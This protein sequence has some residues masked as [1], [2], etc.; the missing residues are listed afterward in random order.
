MPPDP[1]RVQAVFLAA[2][3]C[4]E[5]SARAAVLDAECSGDAELRRRVE[6]LLCAHDEFDR[7]LDVA[8]A[9]F[10]LG[11]TPLT[12]TEH[13]GREG[14]ADDTSVVTPKAPDLTSGSESNLTVAVSA[15][16]APPD[17]THRAVPAIEGY[18]VL[19]ELGRGGMGVVYRARQ[20]LLN[21]SCVL[22]MILAGVHAD[23]ESVVC[24]LAEAEAVARLQHPNIVQIHHVGEADGL[25]FFELE[26]VDGGSLDRRLDG[27][28]WPARPAAELIAA[29][30]RGVAEAH[31]QGIIHRDLKPGNVLLA[32]DGTPKIT[33]FGLAK[34]LDKDSG[35]TRTDS[36]MGSP[37]YMAPEQAAGTAKL[38]GPL[39]DVYALGAILYELL[40]GGAPFR[41]T[42]ALE[43][44]EQ[45][46]HAEP[47]P[48][49]RLVPGLPR[50]VETIALKCLQ[51]EPG[52]R[53]ESAAALAE[54]LE[55]FRGGE[56]IVARP[57]PFWERGIKWARRRP[58]IAS[59][60]AAVI[61]LLAALLGLGVLSYQ[62]ITS[63]LRIAQERREAAEAS[64]REA[65]RQT[66]VADANFARARKAVDD[67]FTTVSESQLLK[68]PG[69][70]PLRGELLESALRFYQDFL[71]ERGD[72]P[73]LRAELA[74]TQSRIGRIQAE[75]GVAA[76]ARR[77]LKSAIATYRAEIARN[78]QD[79]A[80]PAA[81]ADIWLALGDLNYNYGGQLPDPKREM[82]AA[83]QNNAELREG[84]ARS[85]PDDPDCQGDLAEAFER[86]A[87]AQ[88]QAGR[89][90]L[91]V[92]LRGAELR[93]A[94]FL[95]SPDEPRHNFGLGE[96]MANLA[97]ALT[98]SGRHE[99]ALAMYLRGQEYNRF[100]Y[101]RLPHMIDYGCDLGTSYM[102]AVRAYRKLGRSDEAVAEARKAVEHCR[103]LVR[104]HPAVP[105]VKRHFVWALEALVQSQHDAGRA[106]EA[107][108]TGRELGQWLD[109]VED[110]PNSLFDGACWHARLSLWADETKRS[111][112]DPGQDEAHREADRAVEQLQR[113]IESGFADLDAIRKNEALDP[114]RGRADFQKLVADLEER[115]T[116]RP[117]GAPVVARSEDKPAPVSVSRAERVF[118]ARADWVAVLHAVGVIEEGRNRH[119]EARAALDEA[120][121]FCEQLLGERP[122]EAPLRAPLAD[123]HRA[124]GSLDLDAGRLGE[125]AGAF[126]RA[127]EAA[128]HDPAAY[129]MVAAVHAR[130]GRWDLAAET[131]AMLLERNPEDH[132]HWCLAAALRARAG[133]PD[134]YRR[135][136]RQMLD[137][138]RETNDPAIAERAAKYCLLLP[139][140]GPERQD[141]NQLAE[142]AVAGTTGRLRQW[143]RAAKGLADYRAG[144]FADALVA[145]DNAEAATGGR[146]DW[147]FE[148]PAGCVRA[149][150]LLCLGRRDEA[151]A[152]LEKVSGL[153]RA[154]APQ[155]IAPDPGW[156]WPDLLI[157]DILHGEAEALIVFDAAFPADPF[158][159]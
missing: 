39:A 128:P 44:I 64:R 45:V 156:F 123:T 83:C 31:R 71:Q 21:R 93:L 43:I 52:K 152:A 66:K 4:H 112:A 154:N 85:R 115:L 127:L 151:R 86:L 79:L 116:S 16:D 147:N 27:T 122:I 40:T 95:K 42:S 6:T 23:A 3:E 15:G 74:A 110:Q 33:D 11:M 82:L 14:I 119:H 144:R 54:D 103:R 107:A 38:V 67:S 55:R 7:S 41:G 104:D 106:A 60:A 2:L 30:A 129:R 78:P 131:L 65:I 28:P 36:I 97:V 96:S 146:G 150:A 58:A 89:D 135:L 124:L 145:I 51:K 105:I 62:R 13:Q 72:D 141:A 92:R 76:E 101:D 5:P 10:R 108:R 136:C 20:I 133:D 142:R 29:L 32:A 84:L 87:F 53:Y 94:R 121:V 100:A 126:T 153:Y 88:D 34:A 137:R 57:V 8:L 19:G 77:T 98:N 91:P 111:V 113:A 114:L 24:F 70:Q 80:L 159:R 25:P 138:F 26:Y 155:T 117:R 143:A 134:R 47:V 99:D 158:A 109:L 12:G 18:E 68:V 157:C 73:V 90:G 130:L 148:V 120:R 59:L 69:L 35:L 9:G 81:L 61:L 46:R 118:R 125:A 1:K 50:D 140:S 22:K 139:S 17:R 75:L 102:N 132:G 37:G 149:M 49:S 56:P 48:P 63:A